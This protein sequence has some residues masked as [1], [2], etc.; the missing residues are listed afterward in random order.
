MPAPTPSRES[1]LSESDVQAFADGMLSPARAASVRDYLQSHPGEAHRVAFYGRLNR[2]MQ[3]AFAE[4]AEGAAV[5][6]VGAS[7]KVRRIRALVV[8][9]VLIAVAIVAFDISNSALNNA[10]IGAFGQLTSHSD[11]TSGAG[12]L[13]A[14][15]DLSGAGFHPVAV[16]PVG[17]GMFSHATEYV[18]RNEGGEPAVLLT[19]TDWFH[20]GRSQWSAYR[21]GENRLLAWNS[22]GIRYVLAGQAQTRGLMRAADLMTSR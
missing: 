21:V 11:M 13:K 8:T 5:L 2:Q 10:S 17:V 3:H 7:R 18:Y 22:H 1:R 20:R 12:A 6:R 14:A 16:R 4:P 15:P 19:A 9:F